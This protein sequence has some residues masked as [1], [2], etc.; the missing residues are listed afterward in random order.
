[1]GSKRRLGVGSFTEAHT[2]PLPSFSFQ[3]MAFF[4]SC[5]TGE[6]VHQLCKVGKGKKFIDFFNEFGLIC[7]SVQVHYVSLAG[8]TTFFFF[9]AMSLVPLSFGFS[10][11]F[12][13]DGPMNNKR[14][15]RL[16][17]LNILPGI[18]KNLTEV[19]VSID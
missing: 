16:P 17:I 13:Q 7:M 15:L 2:R 11:F 14:G 18:F 1:M 12:P 9:G 19:F 3:P 8:L 4:H 6:I 10:V 5:S